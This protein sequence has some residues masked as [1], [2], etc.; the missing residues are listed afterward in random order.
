[1]NAKT[2]AKINE[3]HFEVEGSP[4]PSGPEP[5]GNRGNTMKISDIKIGAR[6][7]KDMGDLAS[8]ARSMASPL[9]LLNPIIVNQDGRLWCGERRLRA[10][11]MLGWDTI[12]VIIRSTP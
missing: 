11:Q 5:A 7:R 2:S 8:L 3:A 9:G 6:V 1:M 12:P 4:R 10:A